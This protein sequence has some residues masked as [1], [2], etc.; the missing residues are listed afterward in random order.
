MPL[1][2]KFFLR[3]IKPMYGSCL[4]EIL[5]EYRPGSCKMLS[6]TQVSAGNSHMNHPK[7]KECRTMSKNICI[8]VIFNVFVFFQLSFAQYFNQPESVIYDD[9]NGRYLVSNSGSDKIVGLT[10]TDTT[11]TDFNGSRGM[12]IVD[13]ILYAVKEE[14]FVRGYDLSSSETVLDLEIRGALLLNDI[15]ADSSG[16][17]YVTDF[18]G[19]KIYKVNPNTKKVSIYVR[20]NLE[21]PNGILYDEENNR[22]LFCESLSRKIKA[23]DLS[24]ATVSTILSNGYQYMDGLTRDSMGNIY[25]SNWQNHSV[26]KYDPAFADAPELVSSGHNGPADIFINQKTNVLAVPNYNSRSVSFIPLETTPADNEGQQS[27]AEYRLMQ[28]FPNPFNPSTRISYAIP[29]SDFVILTV[30][31]LLGRKIRT[32]VNEFQMADM[33]SVRFDAADLSSGIY[34][35]RLQIGKQCVETRKMQLLQ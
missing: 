17:L 27:P 31:D 1:I 28:N 19:N 29:H 8:L 16:T 32:L 12:T 33:Y 4:R 20:N 23:V 3:Y 21:K 35:Y 2:Y 30:Y 9:L 18:N 25:V 11:I 14:M 7:H 13:N 26:Y 24:D 15:T 22:L 10:S 34:F 5:R 6:V